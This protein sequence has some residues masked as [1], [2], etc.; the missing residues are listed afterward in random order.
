MV[1]AIADM[2]RQFDKIIEPV[3][4]GQSL[5]R[6]LISKN[7][8]LSG[9]G[10]GNTS[11]SSY[12]YKETAAAVTEYQILQSFAD[13]PDLGRSA[14]T[15]PIQQDMVTIKRRDFESMRM[16]GY[17]LDSDISIQMAK[18]VS[19]E[20]DK[21]IIQGWN[22]G[23]VKGFFQ[24]AALS[25]TGYDFGT[26]KGAI[27]TV[28]EGLKQLNENKIYSQGYNLVVHPEQYVDLLISETTVGVGEYPKIM[29]LLNTNAPGQYGRVYSC[30][31][32]EP[33]TGFMAP[34]ATPANQ[35]YCD[36]IEAQEP[37]HFISYTGGG[38]EEVADINLQLLGA[39]V[40][41]FKHL[42]EGGLSPAVIKFTNLA[43]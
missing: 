11:V 42:D 17:S 13:R 1:H 41:R 22:N 20:L 27:Q 39:A 24:I 19:W 4:T 3:L 38:N 7:M 8:V 10:I 29:D 15:I 2:G 21:T 31:H 34:V 14:V 36:L 9:K 26:Y 16:Q 35:L 12:K 33:G 40:P 32:L 28:S 30:E 23:E 43:G 5:G 37:K 25:H 18:N 6:L